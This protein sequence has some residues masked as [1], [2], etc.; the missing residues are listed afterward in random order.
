[1]AMVV[2][3]VVISEHENVL[4]TEPDELISVPVEENHSG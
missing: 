2:I 4:I 3:G 1:M